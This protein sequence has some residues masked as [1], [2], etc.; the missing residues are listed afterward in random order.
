MD[1]P[2]NRNGGHTVLPSIRN[3]AAAF[4][5][6][7]RL[8]NDHQRNQC[9]GANVLPDLGGGCWSCRD[10]EEA[11]LGFWNCLVLLGIGTD[12]ECFYR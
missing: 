5:H 12:L 9:C 1:L 2:T 11:A 8:A 10:C 7:L 4:E 3:L 6:C